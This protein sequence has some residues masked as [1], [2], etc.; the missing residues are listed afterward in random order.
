MENWCRVKSDYLQFEVS[1]LGNV[2]KINKKRPIRIIKQHLHRQGYLRVDM[3]ISDGNRL[4]YVHRLVAHYFIPNPNNLPIVNHINGIK[5]DNRA[6][7][8]EWCTK[9][10]NSIHAVKMGLVK[11][12]GLKGENHP[13]AKLTN[14]DVAVI[15]TSTKSSSELSNIY[16]I[17]VSQIDRIKTGKSWSAF[18]QTIKP[19]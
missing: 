11:V 12:P 14:N 1:D 3:K 13:S 5:D 8:L 16:S 6:V 15:F 4:H 9:S 18:T 7:N 2:R 19:C 17:S 10:Q